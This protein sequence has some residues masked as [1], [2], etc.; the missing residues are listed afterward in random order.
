MAV[1]PEIVLNDDGTATD[2]DSPIT[3][4]ELLTKYGESAPGGAKPVNVTINRSLAANQWNTIALPFDLDLEYDHQEWDEHIFNMSRTIVTTEAMEIQFEQIENA[5]EAGKPYLFRV[6]DAITSMTFTNKI[7]KTFDGMSYT[8]GDASFHSVF[9]PT[10]YFKDKSYIFLINNRLYYPNQTSGT[11][12]R[13]FRAYFRIENDVRYT[14]PVRLRIA[15]TGE[16]ITLD[17]EQTDET[18]KY[19]ENGILIIERGGVRYDAQG[20]KV[21]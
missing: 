9:T 14:A 20:K 21:D 10:A 6:G 1:T 16:T 18:R 15:D 5:I 8:A 17:E 13:S 12:V 7:L 3:Y 4:N 11:R 2:N 19:I